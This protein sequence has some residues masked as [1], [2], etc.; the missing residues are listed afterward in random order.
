MG[1][2]RNLNSRM[3][4]MP[5]LF[6]DNQQ[7]D[8]YK[9]VDSLVHKAP[10]SHKVMLILQGFNP[11]TVY[12]VTFV[13]HCKRAKTTDNIA[14]AK[15]SASDED[16]DTKKHKKIPINS[17]AVK[18]TVRNVVRKTPQFI[19]LFVMK[20]IFTPQGSENSSKQGLQLRQA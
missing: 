2:V 11:E 9:I 7:L 17:R 16:S 1:L 3:A 14:M 6:D 10:R 15:V 8:E 12:L 20:T 19:F 5:P 18:K 13:E 4:R